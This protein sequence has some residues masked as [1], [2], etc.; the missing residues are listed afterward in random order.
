MSCNGGGS[1]NQVKYEGELS[2]VSGS[3]LKD[4]QSTGGLIFFHVVMAACYRTATPRY[5]YNR[6]KRAVVESAARGVVSS[7]TM[8]E[9]KCKH[10]RGGL[11]KQSD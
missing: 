10:R 5:T 1:I 2:S 4:C 8:S 9:H 6:K 11:S 3:M 7:V